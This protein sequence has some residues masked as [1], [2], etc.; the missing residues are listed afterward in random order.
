[1]VK[2]ADIEA[3]EKKRADDLASRR[4]YRPGYGHPRHDECTRGARGEEE[5]PKPV[6]AAIKGTIH[7][8]RC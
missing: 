1:M 3:D 7:K 8:P 6:E 4:K 5:E 2:A